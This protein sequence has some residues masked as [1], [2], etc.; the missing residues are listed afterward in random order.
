MHIS[1]TRRGGFAGLRPP[2]LVVDVASLPSGVAS[3]IKRLVATALTANRPSPAPATAP[4]QPDRFSYTLTITSDDGSEVTHAFDE[5]T[6][7]PPLTAL[8]ET[9]QKVGRK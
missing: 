6:A 3:E 8:V 9:L 4:A 5:T 7:T 2:P 1:L